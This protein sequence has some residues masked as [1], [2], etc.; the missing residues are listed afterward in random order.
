MK[1]GICLRSSA[2]LPEAYAYK[3]FL[4][5]NGFTVE[6]G[7][8]EELSN[9]LDLK[10][11]FLG[12]SIPFIHEASKIIIPEVHEYGSLSIPPL[13]K[14][15]DFLKSSLNTLP[16]GR[17]FL[18]SIV[19]ENLYLSD[20]KPFIFRDM[21]I[22]STFFEQ[23]KV[24]PDFDVI[25]CGAEHRG[26]L[27]TINKL[28]DL[29]LKILIVGDFSK[30]FR[31]NL[32]AKKTITFTGRIE[33]KYLPNLYQ[34]CR[35]GLNLT[36]DRYPFNI[37]TSTKTLEYCAAGLGVISNKYQWVEQFELSRS[38]KFLWLE[39]IMSKDDIYKFNFIKP[40]VSDLEWNIVLEKSKIIPFL[41]SLKNQSID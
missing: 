34:S 1:I 30:E 4:T 40:N 14:I 12:F 3:D 16:V 10:L 19:K 28:N 2:Y 5:L 39:N 33:R 35:Y 13:A 18:N 15:K 17:I 22:D 36:P 11:K 9:N 21:G 38:A 6:L 27:K 31:S 25:Y 41:H 7:F 26:L 20:K 8:E 32:N 37:Q 29:S 23:R 24:V